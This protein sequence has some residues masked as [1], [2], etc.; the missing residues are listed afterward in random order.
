MKIIL[1][2]EGDLRKAIQR[3]ERNSIMT[4]SEVALMLCENG[5]IGFTGTLS[6][7]LKKDKRQNKWYMKLFRRNK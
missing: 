4:T 5:L 6:K 1:H 7:E 3:I 2:P